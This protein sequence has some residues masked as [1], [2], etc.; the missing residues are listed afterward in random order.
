MFSN[1][2]RPARLASWDG[3]TRSTRCDRIHWPELL[4]KPVLAR[5]AIVLAACLVLADLVAGA[6]PPF[7]YRVGQ[8]VPRDIRARVP[9]EVVDEAETARILDRAEETAELTGTPISPVGPAVSR[10]PAG[11]VIVRHDQPISQA[12]LEVL[13]F[14]HAAYVR[15]LAPAYLRARWLAQ[16]AIVGVLAATVGV[17]TVRFQPGLAGNLRAVAGIC[18]LA[19]GALW[20]AH[21]LNAPPWH[22]AAF[23]L[24]LVAMVLTL[25]YNP[26]FALFLGVCLAILTAL[27]RGTDL[28]PLI[29]HLGGLAAAVLGVRHV[30]TRN[31]PVEVGLLAGATYAFMTV[32]TDVL[33]GQTLRF[34]ALDAGRNALAGILAGFVLT[35]CLPLVER[36]FGVVTDARLLELSDSSHPL[37]QELLRRAPGTY[38]HSMTVATLAEGA[39]EAIGANPLLTRVGC[40][41]HDI[42]KML[43][44]HYFI[45]NQ[46]GSNAHDHLEPSLSTLIIVGHVKD[47][48]ALGERYRL[49]RPILDFIVEHHGTTLVEYFYREALR[50]QHGT[51]PEALEPTFRYP[52][53]K[54]Q[55]RE[56]GI[57]MLADAAESASRAVRNPTPTALRKLVRDLTMKRLLDGQFDESGLTLADLKVIEEALGKGLI[58]VYHARVQYEVPAAIPA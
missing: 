1:S 14:E 11:L 2:R 12:S 4:R 28:S 40:Y 45:E 49:P 5:V 13:E 3:R 58:A 7:P 24:A 42:G 43:K 32:A 48:A 33:A 54:P 46:T 17:Y 6:G 21:V 38:T 51:S 15:S 25:A 52:G 20:L 39:A 27:A 56:A 34:I 9:F 31:R 35:G 57:I 36:L 19:I 10:F 18:G 37:L 22:A 55:T 8:T 16:F 50:L 53:P 29:V 47:G 26:P 44:P 41:Y 23:P 30:R